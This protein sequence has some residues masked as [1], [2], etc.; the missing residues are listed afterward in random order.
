MVEMTTNYT[1]EH[2]PPYFRLGYLAAKSEAATEI[3]A[4]KA[5]VKELE[6]AL[7]YES[8]FAAGVAAGHTPWL[9]EADAR[10][11]TRRM[12]AALARREG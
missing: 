11:M 10:A 8:A 1:L 5:R 12:Q 9:D 6:A 7:Y 3:A 2:L 4:L